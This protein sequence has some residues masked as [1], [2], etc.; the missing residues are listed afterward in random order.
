MAKTPVG[1]YPS[2]QQKLTAGEQHLANAVGNIQFA[3]GQ[4]Y[5]SIDPWTINSEFKLPVEEKK[6]NLIESYEGIDDGDRLNLLLAF[7]I[8]RLGPVDDW[9]GATP[10]ELKAWLDGQCTLTHLRTRQDLEEL[11]DNK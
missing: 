5:T 4:G 6:L 9:F 10:E 1:D 11:G 2:Y 3:Q 8:A 7:L